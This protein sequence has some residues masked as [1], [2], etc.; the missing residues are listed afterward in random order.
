[1]GRLLGKIDARWLIAFGFACTAAALHHMTSL[2]LEID[3]HTAVMYRIYQSAGLAFLFVPIHTISYVGVPPEKSQQA[4]PLLNLMRNL[5]GSFGISLLTTIL[6]RRTQ[7]HQ[8]RLVEH[9]T[10]YDDPAR[11]ALLGATRRIVAHGHSLADASQ[12]ALAQ[13]YGAVGRQAATLA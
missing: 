5:G 9:V 4:S 7:M 2:S 11:A 8:S 3:F 10:P 6:F 1:V 12:R 13:L